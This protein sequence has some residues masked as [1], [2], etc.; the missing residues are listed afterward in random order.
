MAVTDPT[1]SASAPARYRV[2]EGTLYRRST[3]PVAHVIRVHSLGH[4]H[5]EALVQ[6]SYP[7]Y[8]VDALSPSAL[9]DA[10]MAEGNIW[11]GGAWRTAPPE[12]DQ[13]KL[14]R[15]TQNRERSARRARTKVRRLCKSRGL[16]S[17]LTLTYG[18]NMLDRDRMARDFDVFIKRLRRVVPDAQY[19]CV[20]ERQKR[21]AWHAHIAVARVMSHYLHKG[22]LVKSYD[23]LRALWRGVIGTDYGNC[24]VS[25]SRNRH[26][27]RSSAK[28]AAYMSKYIGKGFADLQLDGD[29]YRASG[30]ALPAPFSMRVPTASLDAA[31][32]LMR[33]LI[34]ADIASCVELYGFHLDGGGYFMTLSG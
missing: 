10:A 11:V 19:V 21:G 28:L 22:A 5:T 23:L 12:S 7:W 32:E 34:E 20:F 26:I 33:H 4:G 1:P 27:A 13:D 8:E 29:S 30:G 9:T 31:T 24:D 18:E 15:L 14:H 17:L 3:E 6:P 25:K 2:I 16:T